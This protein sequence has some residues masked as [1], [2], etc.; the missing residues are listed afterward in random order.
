M[1]R[2]GA[3]AVIARRA[4]LAAMIASAGATI[5]SSP[6]ALPGKRALPPP[7]TV[8]LRWPWPTQLPDPYAL[9][10]L[11]AALLGSTLFPPLYVR[12]IDGYLEPKLAS[13]A[14]KEKKPGLR[15]DL[16]PNVRASDVV[17]SITKARAGGA[18]LLLH[19]VP[20]PRIDGAHGVLFPFLADVDGLMH[21]LSSPLCG[22]SRSE[23]HGL[24]PTG[25]FDVTLADSASEGARILRLARRALTGGALPPNAPSHVARFE[26]E[27]AIDLG[28]SLRAFERGDTD[29]GWLGDG[30]FEARTGARTMD[31]GPLAYLAM[32]AG[33]DAPELRNPGAVLGLV[34]SIAWDRLGHLGLLRRGHVG[35]STTAAFARAAPIVPARVPIL[36]R[37][38]MPIVVAAAAAIARELGGAPKAISDGEFDAALASR[39]FALAL[40]VVRPL[41]DSAE[42]AALSLATFDGASIA[43]SL[44]QGPRGIASSGR[45]ALGWEIS[46][47]GA[48]ASDVWIPRAP[49]GGFDLEAG[50]VI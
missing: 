30:L 14:P 43:P 32:A 37:A 1:G 26:L 6:Y 18:R 12:A 34:E 4:F 36:V 11:T 9:N 31:L 46:L 50:G 3:G 35:R 2:E 27:G 10:D 19:D 29:V 38:S 39:A 23:P 22:I 44:T 48:Q 33:T 13:A 41:D 47:L 45:A 16:M 49:F 42:G 7:R 15:I 20:V 40:E 25:S 24:E 28:A 21:R 5:A 17:A 8:R